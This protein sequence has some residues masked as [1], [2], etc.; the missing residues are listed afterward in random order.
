M[1]LNIKCIEINKKLLPNV[2]RYL[3]NNE[4]DYN[5]I[6]PDPKIIAN[7]ILRRSIWIEK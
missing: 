6:W 4:I 2:K 5:F 3:E 7:N 1:P